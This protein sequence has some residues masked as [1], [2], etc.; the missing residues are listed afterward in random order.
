MKEYGRRQKTKRENTGNN[1]KEKLNVVA[2]VRCSKEIWR[3]EYYMF[4]Y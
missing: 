3:N 4:V 1:K 2:M